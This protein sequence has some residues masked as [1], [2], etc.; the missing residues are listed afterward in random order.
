MQP[1]D[2]ETA[3]LDRNILLEASAG[4]GKTYTL[5]RLVMRLITEREI[6]LSRILVVTFTNMAAREMEERI[7]RLLSE[8]LRSAEG[9]R[10]ELLRRAAG[11]FDRA[12]VYTIHGFCS[13]VLKTLPFECGLPPGVETGGEEEVT[14]R[15]IQDWFRKNEDRPDPF[16]ELGYRAAWNGAGGFGQL[17][18][19][20]EGL[21]HSERTDGAYRLV[22]GPDEEDLITGLCRDW[23][24]SSLF[25]G[26]RLLAEECRALGSPDALVLALKE[27][28]LGKRLGAKTAGPFYEKLAQLD[29]FEDFYEFLIFM[30]G[31]GAGF[32][33]QFRQAREGEGRGSSSFVKAFVAW[34]DLLPDIMVEEKKSASLIRS[35]SLLFQFR[36]A[37]EVTEERK[38]ERVRSGKLTYNDLIDLVHTLLAGKEKKSTLIG[39]LGNRYDVLLVD[40]FQDTDI[41]QWEIF[42]CLFGDPGKNYFLIGDPKQSIYRFRG[43]DLNVYLEVRDGLPE[44]N[45]YRLGKNYRSHP[46]LLEGFN[47]FFSS[48]FGKEGR[49]GTIGYSPVGAG[50]PEV[51]ALCEK[52]LPTAPVEFLLLPGEPTSKDDVEELW[53]NAQADH[54]QALLSD[55][56]QSLGKEELKASHMAVLLENNRQCVRFHKLLTDRAVPAVIYQE[57]D[58]FSTREV[59]LPLLFLEAMIG[60]DRG[61]SLKKLL[62]SPLVGLKAG[63][64]VFLEESGFLDSLVL[65]FRL[66]REKTDRGDL[67]GQFYRFCRLGED[68]AAVLDEGGAVDRRR[69]DHLG[70]NFL[71]RLMKEP[72]GERLYTNLRHIL[73]ILHTEQIHK[74]LNTGELFRFCR[75]ELSRSHGDETFQVRLDRDGEAVRI[76]TLHKSKGLQFPL[77]FF[78]GGLYSEIVNKNSPFLTFSQGKE[79]WIDYLKSEENR[80]RA[81]REAWEE[82]KRLYY[83][84]LTRA[85]SKLYMPLYEGWDKGWLS[86]FYLQIS[87]QDKGDLNPFD[88][89]ALALPEKT[90]F[91]SCQSLAES[92][93]ELF[94]IASPRRTEELFSLSV[95]TKPLMKPTLPSLRL[96]SRYPS[97][98]SFS[99]LTQDH[100][101]HEVLDENSQ[102]EADYDRGREEI[103]EEEEILSPE[104]IPGGAGLGNLV[105]TLFEELDYEEAAVGR[106][107]FLG[108]EEID[109]FVKERALYYFKADW[110]REFGPTVKEMVWNTLNAS[111]FP[112]E[113][114]EVF[115]RE[116]PAERRLHEM[117]FLIRLKE[118]GGID[119]KDFHSRCS[120]GYLKGFIDLIFLHGDRYY[121]AD[122]KTTR[123]AAGERE[124]YG[125]ESVERIMDDHSYHLQYWIYTAAF[126]LFMKK[127][128]ADFDYDRDCGGIFYFFNRGMAPETPGRGLFFTRPSREELIRFFQKF[129]EE[130][131][132][133]L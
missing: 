94:R 87:G 27:E 104:T 59:S 132:H 6:P 61:E 102:A 33:T 110:Y 67:I 86:W 113:D 65:R 37:R 125:E 112:G 44:E 10:E 128:G 31:T 84:G 118:G 103:P 108:K 11:E 47:L 122:W 98:L 24:E 68:I 62:L 83:V 71:I 130:N 57:R 60:K 18:G 79:N 52:G 55:P 92:E 119:L 34:A 77:V 109:L 20:I 93:P 17:I 41:R 105:H 64:L 66:Y 106:E 101:S 95:P 49:P 126:Y 8:E 12:S 107:A 56:G 97:L 88:K 4:T 38:A 116:I 29:R 15:L 23:K 14:G 133:D 129:T 51:P 96:Y 127:S 131:H 48:L 120:R 74:R 123:C 54:I 13:H 3:P 90:G 115:L 80:G 25:Q 39:E 99:S 50:K 26:A 1:F 81:R 82:K 40:E 63:E 21:I 32:Y 16:L 42:S 28:G 43:A 19:E 111:L 45:R 72:G 121:I 58:I 75:S 69:A 85:E 91:H 36:C 35:L 89:S 22:P 78:G 9:R 53:L 124:P 70:E 73:E 30:N 46:R 2:W 114:R 76:M 100:S 117:E 5:E 7:G